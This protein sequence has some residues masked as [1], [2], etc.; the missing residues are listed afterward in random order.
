MKEN[1]GQYDLEN[2]TAKFSIKV[3]NNGIK[4]QTFKIHFKIKILNLKLLTH[5]SK[6]F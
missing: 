5:V 4:I 6:S 3:R 2:R 1:K